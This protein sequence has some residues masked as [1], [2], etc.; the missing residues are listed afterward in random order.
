MNQIDT[1]LESVK[2]NEN[3]IRYAAMKEVVRLSTEF[4]LAGSG[5]TELTID[6]ELHIARYLQAKLIALRVVCEARS[7]AA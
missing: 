4:C 7:V 5:R 3:V 2:Q 6:E 1:I